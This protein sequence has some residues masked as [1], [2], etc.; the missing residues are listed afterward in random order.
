MTSSDLAAWTAQYSG[1]T[2]NLNAVAFGG[3]NFIAVGDN[4]LIITSSDGVNWVP[5]PSATGVRIEN[6]IFDN[7]LFIATAD[8]GVIMTSGDGQDWAIHTIATPLNLYAI[9]PNAAGYAVGGDYNFPTGSG[10]VMQLGNLRLPG[11]SHAGFGGG[12]FSF[13]FSGNPNQA[14]RLQSS[15]D[16]SIWSDLYRFTNDFG[17]TNLNDPTATLLGKRFYR[18]VSP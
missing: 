2:N 13:T 6:I 11:L 4:G 5:E 3:G 8:G 17:T 16:L 15:V 18:V 1:T 9:C 10:F 12:R 14:Y 7:G